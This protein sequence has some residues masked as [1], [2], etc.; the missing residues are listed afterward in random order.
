MQQVF[1]NLIKNAVKFTPPGG[2]LEIST[3]NPVPDKI[4]IV[5]RD[6]GVGIEHNLLPRIFEAFQQGGR[7]VTSKFGGLGLGLAISKRVI[8]LHNG[9]ITAQSDGP[10]KGATFTVTLDAIETSLLDGPVVLETDGSS[11]PTPAA[12]LLVEDHPDTGHVLRRM[13]TNAGYTVSLAGTTTAARALAAEKHFDLVVSD[14]G[15]PDGTGLELM[16]HL[17][18]CHDLRGIALSGF[19]TDED[20]GASLRAGFDEHLT[21]P[22]DWERLKEAVA[23]LARGSGD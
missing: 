18:S 15:L 21:K 7:A 20:R 6:N 8:D 17:R 19:G 16:K 10:G 11:A 1:W 4:E 5:L 23:R 13:L 22:V 9:T 14:L 3:R 12:I 2:E